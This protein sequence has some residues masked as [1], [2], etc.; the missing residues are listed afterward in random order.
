MKLLMCRECQDI[1]NLTRKLKSCSCGESSGRYVDNLN[2][3]I[4][5]DCVP[6][7]IDNDSFSLAYRLQKVDNAFQEKT[8]GH[9][10]VPFDAFFIPEAATSIKRI[11]K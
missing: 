2:A 10:G 8:V 4:S 6:I 1:F 11:D 7:G 9:E 3:E 5:G